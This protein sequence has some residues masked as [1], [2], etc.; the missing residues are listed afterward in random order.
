MENVRTVGSFRV[1]ALDGKDCYRVVGTTRGTRRTY[2][3]DSRTF[4][5]RQMKEDL[6]S[7]QRPNDANAAAPSPRLYT[8]A[9]RQINQPVNAKLFQPPA[10][11]LDLLS[12]PS[13]GGRI[14][15]K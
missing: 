1:C 8:F 15:E 3:I 14:L 7:S 12:I 5:L 11:R 4:M 6:G 2:W 10:G 13:G 9:I